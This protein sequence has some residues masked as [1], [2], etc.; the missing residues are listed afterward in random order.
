M[1][2]HDNP[3]LEELQQVFGQDNFAVGTTGCTVLE[4]T[5][6]HSVCE[7]ELSDKHLNAMGNIM[8]GAIFTLC[9][10][11]LA[12]AC[13]VGVEP[14]VAVQANIDFM[15]TTKGK[16]LTATCSCS[17]MGSHVEFYTITAVDDLGKLIAQMSATCYR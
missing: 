17:K 1:I 10:Y 16:K 8:G 5:R 9:D 7:L 15:R 12:V 2:I 6:G 14:T 13:N 3:T 11:A 4:G